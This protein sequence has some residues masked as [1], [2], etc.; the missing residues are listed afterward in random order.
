MDLYEQIRKQDKDVF[1]TLAGE[2]RR[3]REGLELIPS[4]NYVSKAVREA[5]GSI[6]TNKYSEGYPGRRYYGGQTYTDEIEMLAIERAK[7]LFGAKFANVQAHSGANANIAMYM[8]LLEP[9]D[10]VLGMDLSHG[11]HLTHGHPVTYITKFFNFV[12]YKMKDPETG[13]IDYDEMRRVAME[14]KPKIV[15]AGFSAYSREL[16]YEKIAAIAREVGAYAV[17]DAAHIAGLIAGGAAK[18]PFDYGFDIIT[19]TTHKTLRGPRGGLILTR[20]SEELAKKVDK[21]VFPALQ[22]G[23]LMHVI[24]AKAVAFNEALQPSFKTYAAQ[25]LKNAKAMEEVFRAAGVRMLGGG[26][27][28]H[29]ILADVFGSLGIPGKEAEVLLDRVG[30]TLNKNVIADDTRSPMDPS[31]IRFGT[32]A[33]TTRGLKEGESARVAELMLQAMKN[34]GD[35]AKLD[36]VREN[37]RELCAQ[38]PI[39]EALV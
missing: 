16:D 3:E 30:I 6:F 32:P 14:S 36:A 8:A 9:G 35:E 19:S 1:A 37:I 27:S 17:M 5:Q 38:F 4:E 31:G 34:R 25:I 22:G 12:R 18:N 24:A 15:L 10:T 23:P 2:E 39:P 28:N 7:Q 20:E 29:L 11:G 33:I 21:A 26:T 13:E